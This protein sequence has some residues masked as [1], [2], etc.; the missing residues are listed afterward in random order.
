MLSQG[1]PGSDPDLA[2]ASLFT[3]GIIDDLDQILA[4]PQSLLNGC[5]WQLDCNWSSGRG[6]CNVELGYH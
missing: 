5:C 3:E 4:I 1:P 2:A 6:D